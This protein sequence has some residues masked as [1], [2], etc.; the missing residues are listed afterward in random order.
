MNIDIKGRLKVG[1]GIYFRFK[2][3]WLLGYEY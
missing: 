2:L 3:D 1:K